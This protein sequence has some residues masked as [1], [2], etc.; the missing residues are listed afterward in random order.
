MIAR[1][2]RAWATAASAPV[3][4]AFLTGEFISELTKVDGYGGLELLQRPADGE[5]EILVITRWRDL[6]AI[7]AFA[8]EDLEA[9]HVAPRARTLLSRFEDRAR[10]Y[11]MSALTG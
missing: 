4:A 11:E 1:L 3:Y 8:G 10:H 7:R 2:W 5:V 6:D 9:A